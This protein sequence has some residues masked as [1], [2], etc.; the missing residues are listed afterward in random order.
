MNQKI[1][2]KLQKYFRNRKDVAFAFL[3][4]SQ[5]K[6]LQRKISDWDIA[7]YLNDNLSKDQMLKNRDDIL[8]ELNDIIH[9]EID[10]V[11]LN[12]AKPTIADVAM[13]YG[14]VLTIND[15]ESYLKQLLKVSAQATDFRN[16]S[17]SFWQIKQSAQSLTPVERHHLQ[18]IIDFLETEIKDFEQWQQINQFEYERNKAKRLQLERWVERIVNALIDAS[19][20]LLA[21]FKKPLPDTYADTLKNL[22]QLEG[23]FDFSYSKELSQWADLRNIIAHE[24]LDLLWQ[25]ISKFLNEAKPQLEKF[26]DTTKKLLS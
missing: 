11:L 24:Y 9:Q 3:F 25:K 12:I 7:I 15:E 18:K 13:R 5:S 19:K 6:G 8:S 17:D 26:I 10:L 22:Y 21:S 1:I 2:K 14:L 16:F 23:I 4:G 20:I